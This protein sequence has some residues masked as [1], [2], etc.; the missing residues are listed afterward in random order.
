MLSKIFIL[1]SMILG[2]RSMIFEKIPGGDFLMLAGFWVL[3]G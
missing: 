3:R 1:L 2:V